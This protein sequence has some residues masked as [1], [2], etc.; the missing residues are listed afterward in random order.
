[1]GCLGLS[2]GWI[3][4]IK[5]CIGDFSVDEGLKGLDSF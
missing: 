1:M 5:R 3:G 4:N 2:V